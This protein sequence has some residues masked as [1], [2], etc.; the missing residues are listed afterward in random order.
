L[1]RHVILTLATFAILARAA[2]A[3]AGDAP[4]TSTSRALSAP[5]CGWSGGALADPARTQECLAERF[6]TAKQRPVA[7]TDGGARSASVP[8][9]VPPPGG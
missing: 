7:K 1:Y 2:I 9:I 3:F 6:K 4:R 8:V 5:V